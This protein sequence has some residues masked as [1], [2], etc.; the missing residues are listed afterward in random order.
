MRET[1]VVPGSAPRFLGEKPAPRGLVFEAERFTV[2]AAPLEHRDITSL[3][4]LVE[5]RSRLAVRPEALSERGLSPGP[6]L[7]ALKHAAS[8]KED[9]ELDLGDGRHARVSELSP[10]LLVERSGQKIV[11]VTD[12]ADSPRNRQAIGELARD[13]DLFIC[14]AT[15]TRSDE[16]RARETAHLPAFAAAELAREARVGRLLPFHLSPRYEDTPELIFRELLSIFPRV[17]VPRELANRILPS[18]R[19]L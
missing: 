3:S 19:D 14:E 7:D 1:E 10:D 18:E 17:Q 2:H 4:Y 12:A 5:E 6:W 8:R 9:L 11:Y 16:D 13:V 15:F